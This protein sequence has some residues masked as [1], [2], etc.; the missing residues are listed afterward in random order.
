AVAG[1]TFIDVF[2]GGRSAYRIPERPDVPLTR[3]DAERRSETSTDLAGLARAV[4][5]ARRG[6]GLN[7]GLPVLAQAGALGW[8]AFRSPADYDDYL[9]WTYNLARFKVTTPGA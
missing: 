8:L 5:E 4:Q 7:E 1:E 9:F 3:V 6:R 2:L